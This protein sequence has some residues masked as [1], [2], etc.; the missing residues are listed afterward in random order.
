[1]GPS[2]KLPSPGATQLTSPSLQHVEIKHSCRGRF[3]TLGLKKESSLVFHH[4]TG[5]KNKLDRSLNMATVLLK[6][7]WATSSVG[8][9]ISLKGKKECQMPYSF[10]W[11]SLKRPS[12]I[13]PQWCLDYHFWVLFPTLM[14]LILPTL[15][16]S[17]L[18]SEGSANEAWPKWLPFSFPILLPTD[19]VYGK[20]QCCCIPSS[21][22]IPN[23][24]LC[25]TENYSPLLLVQTLP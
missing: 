13:K 15:F 8:L 12:N 18:F 3:I 21:A 16:P 6:F 24:R 20:Y 17:V 14:R 25:P 22:V 4:R 1:M 10:K 9:I 5:S 7:F 11:N 2:W 19:S 23:R